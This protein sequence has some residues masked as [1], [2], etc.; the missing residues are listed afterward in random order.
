MSGAKVGPAA[1]AALMRARAAP[2]AAAAAAGAAL[3]LA[4]PPWGAWWLAPLGWA[5]LAALTAEAGPRRAF[6]LGWTAG[7]VFFAIA[8]SWIAEAFMVDA[9]RHAWM[10][11]F[12]LAGLCGGLALFWGAGL[13][14][15]AAMR[16][17]GAWRAVAFAGALTL[18]EAARARVLTGFPWALPAHVWADAPVIQT[19]ALFGQEALG[20]VTLLGA[21]LPVFARA[22]L[23]WAAG[24]AALLAAAWLWGAHRLAAPEPSAPGPRPL[25]RIVQPNVAQALKWDPALAPVHWRDLLALTAAPRADG[26]RP[27]VAIWPETATAYLPDRDAEARRQAAAAARAPVLAGA[28]RF[29][30]AAGWFNALLVIGADGALEA[31]YDKAHLV[32]FG[33]YVPLR[34]ALERLGLTGLVGQGFA[35]GPG[36]RTIRAAGLPPFA[37]RICYEII[38]PDELPARRPDWIV[39]ITNDAWFG[40]SAGPRQHL[41]QARFRAIEQGLPVARAANTGISAMIDARG[42]ILARLEL[43]TRGTLDAPL[44]PA[45]APTPFARTGGWPWL[46]LI[47]ALTALAATRRRAV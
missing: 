7:A 11:P 15:F 2:F 26:R 42:R 6:A 21:A 22:R 40:D 33:E 27:D 8:I 5:G 10:A 35:A 47:G 24:G 32:P 43:G 3:A 41:A 16:A 19:L 31:V 17:A 30:P 23:A 20:F 37:P 13:A 29:D 1:R 28:R 18:A 38:F 12:A 14:G 39:Q 45:L 36:P 46:A 44:P 9:A 25:V 34:G 4:Q